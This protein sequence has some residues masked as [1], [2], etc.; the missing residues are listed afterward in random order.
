MAQNYSSGIDYEDEKRIRSRIEELR[1]GRKIITFVS[2]KGGVGKSNLAVNTAIA[3]S[4]LGVRTLVADADF[5]L[6]DVDLLIG[7]KS[8]F[9]LR[10]FLS[11]EKKMF[12]LAQL[13]F[14]GVRFIS[15][16]NGNSRML[17]ISVDETER[18]MNGLRRIQ[19]PIDIII[20]DG[21]AGATDNLMKVL[22]LSDEAVVVT[23]PEP[24]AVTDSYSLIRNAKSRKVMPPF[25]VII[26]RVTDTADAASVANA[27]LRLVGKEA[28]ETSISY[29]PEDPAVRRAVRRSEP[30]LISEP[31]SDFSRA[32]R[33]AARRLIG[34]PENPEPEDAV[35]GMRT[36]I[37]KFFGS[38]L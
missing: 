23:V 20:I 31:D 8:K 28:D 11:G 19:L 14:D 37:R 24:P 21:Q 16:G 1:R 7:L 13:G 2:G 35:D 32:V 25:Q 30:C 5:G 18:I 27:F 6:A 29:I 34:I 38:K 22:Q 17:R 15:G 36:K 3:L 9:S 33:Q 12:E 4:Q 10:H 26:N